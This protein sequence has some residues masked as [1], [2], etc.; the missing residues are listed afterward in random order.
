MIKSWGKFNESKNRD[1]ALSE[2]REKFQ[3]IRD[4][5]ADFE[6]GNM[7][8]DYRLLI[9]GEE[10]GD[11]GLAFNP[12]SGDFERW[13]GFVISQIENRIFYLGLEENTLCFVVNLRLPIVK[14]E[15]EQGRSKLTTTVIDSEGIKKFED[16]LVTNSRLTSEGYT[17]KYD[18]SSNHPEYKPLK[19]LIYF[20]V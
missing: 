18:L 13:F 8:G 17:V 5:F 2:V 4:I 20:S 1:T 7:V 12:K 15:I 3:E 9:K 14:H 10:M 19:M 11:G 6:D 16:I